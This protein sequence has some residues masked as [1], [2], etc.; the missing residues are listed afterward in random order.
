M[1]SWQ[2]EGQGAG[3]GAHSDGAGG[4]LTLLRLRMWM[5]EPLERLYL[6]ARLVDSAG[7]LK[8]GA[9]ASRR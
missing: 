3:T 9:L 1:A 6:M 2:G 5:Q 4:G 8:G 7:P